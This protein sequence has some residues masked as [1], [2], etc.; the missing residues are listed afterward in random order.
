VNGGAECLL[1]DEDAAHRESLRAETGLVGNHYRVDAQLG[2]GGIAKVYRVTDE[3][4]GTRLA[5]KKLSATGGD[6]SV[7]RAMFELEYHT[8]VQLEHPRIVRAFDYGVDHD[9]AYY[10]MELLE[11]ADAR[12]TLHRRE[13]GVREICVLLRDAA[14]ALALIHSR[15]MV[16][17]D[18]SPRN[19]WCTPNGRAKLIDFGTLTAMG[20]QTRIAGTPPFVP[21]E[22]LY[23]Q[24]LDARCD[25]FALGALAYYLLTEHNA[26]PAREMADLQRVWNQRP[27]APD[28]R[29]PDVPRALSDL[30][31]AMLNLDA[32][33]RPST[34]AEVVERLTAIAELPSEDER[35]LAAA[36]LTSPKLVARQQATE[37]LQKRLARA[38]RGRGSAI[39]FVAKPGLGKSRMLSSVVLEAKLL[40]AAVISANAAA[41]G[42]D[43]LS[44]AGTLAERLLE[45]LPMTAA[46]VVDSKDALGHVSPA[47]HRAFGGAPLAEPPR[48]EQKQRVTKAL[49]DLFEAACR[50]QTLVIAVD[51]VHRADGASLRVLAQLAGLAH[52]RRLLLVAS[53]DEGALERPPPALE[54]LV[55]PADRVELPPLDAANTH[56]LLGSLFGEGPGLPEAASWL[57]ELSRGNPQACMQYAQYLVDDGLASYDGG[58]WKLPANLRERGLPATLGAM[59]D[60][61][62]AR[63]GGDAF[64]LALGLSLARD[65]S[66]SAWQPEQLVQMQDLPRLIAS[67]DAGR[68]VAALDELLRAGMI[69]QHEAHYVVAQRA[70]DDALLRRADA[71]LCAEVH[72]RLAAIFADRSYRNRF[73]MI[74]ELQRAGEHARA[75][76]AV[77][78]QAQHTDQ[79]ELDWGSMRVS[80]SA[81]CAQRALEHWQR[82]GGSPRDGIL[83]RR[84]LLVLCSVYDWS[85][86]RHGDAQLAQLRGDAGL[87]HWSATDPLAPD[88]DRA[89]ECLK[90]AQADF[91]R[92]PEHE[93]GH[94]PL[95]AL[96]EIG[97]CAIPLSGA[98][99][100]SHDVAR[101]RALP[102]VLDPLRPL[103]PVLSLIADTC[104]RAVQRVTGRD[105]GE[106]VL[107]AVDRFLNATE[108][109]FVL[110]R[111][112]AAVF[113]HVQAVEDARCGR[114]RALELMDRL[115][116]EAGDDMFLVLHGRWLACAFRG[117]AALAQR[118]RGRA[119]AITEDDVWR[120]RAFLF[121]EAQLHALTGDLPD[122]NHAAEAIAELARAFDGWRPWRAWA[123]AAQHVLRGELAAAEADLD[124]A[125][126][127]APAGEHRA[128]VLAAPMHAEV[129]LARGDADGALR[130]AAA[131]A[132][133]VDALALDR[134]AAIAA[135]RVAALAHSHKADHGAAQASIDRAFMI[136]REQAYDG[137]PFALLHEAQARVAL[138]AG[139]AERCAG[140]L[141]ALWT[142]L[143]RAHAP[144]LIHAYEELRRAN[145]DRNAGSELPGLA[146]GMHT[147]VAQS[148]STFT[149]VRTRLSACEV[150]T[151]RTRQALQLLL[152]ASGAEVGH[153]FL[154]DARGVFAAASTHVPEDERAADALLCEAQR[155]LAEVLDASKAAAGGGMMQGAVDSALPTLSPEAEAAW[156]PVLLEDC[157]AE[158]PL[159]AGICLLGSR[160]ARVRAP[161]ADLAQA[162]G[163]C[164]LIAGDSAGQSIER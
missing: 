132:G 68:A 66:R 103:S 27:A 131:I 48:V 164:L 15:R 78:E 75:L 88:L 141:S 10:T 77:I 146:A 91:D 95:D 142:L 23:A 98:F 139:D 76:A 145:L 36:F 16:H 61:R 105:V 128:W 49:V 9:G 137:L 59:F 20:A 40:G 38:V 17:R 109:P 52:E 90:R 3:R 100:N 80:L 96:R 123:N 44:L 72:A 57:H 113:G 130:E 34:A 108:L 71:A 89:V 127:L 65:E 31:M 5:L 126:A 41:A 157:T 63:L 116:P 153:L 81:E 160:S 101:S 93:R 6:R 162:I 106:G 120:R 60:A 55:E 122:L 54:R 97:A 110:R 84:T 69:E 161:S 62:V 58:R 33:G 46:A 156:L 138:A 136:A 150:H 37:A 1:N 25:I 67:G 152:E 102:G 4:D 119:E 86:A 143:H 107:N 73:A 115:A 45:T 30:V 28:A 79:R 43:P 134:A 14:S 26:Y 21:P 114:K 112:A 147:G 35:G 151:A 135:H 154:F 70:M 13:L 117:E 124:A 121:V 158:P 83:V 22:A 74:R 47:L 51:D 85:L 24:A 29:R 56:E 18:V 133:A 50:F 42:S 92:L 12:T 64:T 53:C 155:K 140:A 94:S 19:V 39:A 82:V 2:E 163:R 149:D 87:S 111:G 11:G 104:E 99:V 118:F 148:T 7:L 159:V 32:R 8:L 129:R 144:A 125:L